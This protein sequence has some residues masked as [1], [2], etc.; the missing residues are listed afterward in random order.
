MVSSIGSSI[1]VRMCTMKSTSFQTKDA[2]EFG[3]E[4]ISKDAKGDV[5][6]QCF[7]CIH[8]GRDSVEVNGSSGSKRK[9]TWPSNILKI[10]RPLQLSLPF[11]ATCW[12]GGRLPGDVWPRQKGVLQEQGE[13]HQHFALAHGRIVS[14]LPGDVWPR[15]KGVLQEQGEA[16]QHFAL[17]HGPDYGLNRICHPG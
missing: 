9:A 3:M 16:H 6:M 4:V 8:K 10:V 17:A 15:Q 5:T 12:I 13:A 14:R 1:F 2:L 7:F 11:E